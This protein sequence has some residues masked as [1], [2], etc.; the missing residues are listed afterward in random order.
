M[1]IMQGGLA[2]SPSRSIIFETHATSVD[3][4]VGLASGWFDAPLSALGE[5]QAHALGERRRPENFTAIVCSDLTR[6]V[7]TAEIAFR[8]SRLSI[9]QDP[10]LRECDY[11]TFTRRPTSEIDE[12]RALRVDVP[13]P[14]GESYRQVVARVADWLEAWAP[15]FDDGPVLVIGHRATSYAFEYLLRRVPLNRVVSAPWAWQPG[16]TY[17]RDRS[18]D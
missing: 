7:R 10:R 17:D 8:D 11:G 9:I 12:Q 3:N 1:T 18:R 13:F 5:R 6:A 2:S 4:E 15:R 16:W 14:D